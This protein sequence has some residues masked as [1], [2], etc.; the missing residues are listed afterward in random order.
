MQH[1][2]S[3]LTRAVTSWERQR[4]T[5][6]YETQMFVDIAA[7]SNL[8]KRYRPL[9][10]INGCPVLLHVRHRYSRR[11]Y[12]FVPPRAPW[13][14]ARINSASEDAPSISPSN[15]CNLIKRETSI[16]SI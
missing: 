1:N 12:W 2:E 5:L 10:C 9:Y 7:V 6:R 3:D 4:R 13:R 11:N 14:R 15:N 8:V 16:D